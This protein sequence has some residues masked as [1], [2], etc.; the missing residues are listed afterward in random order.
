MAQSL[1]IPVVPVA[2]LDLVA[3]PLRFASRAIAAVLD[4]RR[5][6]V[7]YAM[8]VPVPGGVQRVSEYEVGSPDDLACEL[9][10]RGD[11]V[12]LAGEGAVLH[13]DRFAGLDRVELT[14]PGL[15]WPD[16]SSLLELAAAR[17]QR[18]E[19]CAASE[20]A[21]MYLRKSDAEIELER[22]ASVT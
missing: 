16:A 12:L 18:E 15:S 8:Y 11:E 10:A 2:S 19:F 4:A 13:R 20:V 6:E 1:R 22:V 9:S 3:Y 14:G 17:Y 7:F 5:R 21:P